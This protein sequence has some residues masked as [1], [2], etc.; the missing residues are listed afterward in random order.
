VTAITTVKTAIILGCMES[1][2][3]ENGEWFLRKGSFPLARAPLWACEC[4]CAPTTAHVLSK[5][6]P[7][8]DV[9]CHFYLGNAQEGNIQAWRCGVYLDH[10]I[11]I[12]GLLSS[13]HVFQK[14]SPCKSWWMGWQSLS[15]LGWWNVSS[16][17][18]NN[19]TAIFWDIYLQ[20]SRGHKSLF[21]FSTLS[22][23]FSLCPGR[24][25]ED[26]IL[27]G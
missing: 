3:R 1:N 26:C 8:N 11:N 10:V 17:P 5:T 7:H 4:M 12:S 14:L 2:S 15:G 21:Q 6:F 16:V 27:S 22:P 25:E 19:K 24:V 18:G 23:F 9:G 13:F 20:K